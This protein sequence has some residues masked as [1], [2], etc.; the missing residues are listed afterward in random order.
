M[1]KL[2][3]LLPTC[4]VTLWLI[5]QRD[6]NHSRYRSVIAFTPRE[7]RPRPPHFLWPMTLC[8]LNKS[9]QEAINRLSLGCDA[10]KGREK[11]SRM[12]IHECYW[13]LKW[14]I[15]LL[16]HMKLAKTNNQ[17][18]MLMTKRF[19]WGGGGTNKSAFCATSILFFWKL[20]KS[21]RLM[22]A[23]I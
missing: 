6:F 19:L 15:K 16:L 18:V 17:C 11:Q 10:T 1:W 22:Y 7:K 14:V 2:I 8:D 20:Q 4:R 9:I 12:L 23:P 5:S 13:L 21:A 3:W